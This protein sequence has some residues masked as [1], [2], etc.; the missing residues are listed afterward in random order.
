MEATW[1]SIT[2][3]IPYWYDMSFQ[4][5]IE[6]SNQGLIKVPPPPHPPYH[7]DHRDIGTGLL[8]SQIL[9]TTPRL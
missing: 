4:V 7:Q 5:P 6:Y 1:D 2:E 9:S 3:R 8:R